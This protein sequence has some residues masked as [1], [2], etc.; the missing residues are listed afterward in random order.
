MV[1]QEGPNG[2]QWSPNMTPSGRSKQHLTRHRGKHL[3]EDDRRRLQ[4][5]VPPLTTHGVVDVLGR[6]R[7]QGADQLRTVQEGDDYNGRLKREAVYPNH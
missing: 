3:T 1:P 2:A 7:G 5:I 6:R 4:R